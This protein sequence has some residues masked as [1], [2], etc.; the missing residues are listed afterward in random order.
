MDGL[1]LLRRL[2][3]ML[4]LSLSEVQGHA[5]EGPVLGT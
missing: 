5:C 4:T 2:K 1:V 3:N